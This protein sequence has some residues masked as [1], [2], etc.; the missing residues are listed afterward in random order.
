MYTDPNS[1]NPTIVIAMV[2]KPKLRCFSSRSRIRG[3][4][5][6]SSIQMNSDR[7]TTATAA[8]RRMKG[9]ENQ[10]SL[11]P[12]SSTVRS[13]PQR[14]QGLFDGEFDPDEQRQAHHRNGREAQDEGGG[15]PVVLVALLEHGPIAAAAG[16]GAFRW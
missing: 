16:S 5:M 11:L 1:A 7:L 13:Q 12:S 3:F 9:E 15:E 6:V 2:P 14:D 8:R 10:S 4:S